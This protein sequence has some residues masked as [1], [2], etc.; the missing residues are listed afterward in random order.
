MIEAGHV[1]FPLAIPD[2]RFRLELLGAVTDPVADVLVKGN[3]DTFAVQRWVDVS[4]P[5]GGVTWA[6]I[7]APLVSVGD[8]RIF[9]WDP[10]Y[11]PARAHI[12]SS[13]LNNGWSTNFQEFQGGDFVFNFALRAHGA[14]AG[15]DARFGWETSTPLLGID[16]RQG[17]GTLPPSASL[18]GVAPENVVLVN[19]K[20]AEDGDGWIVRLYE[21][22][23]R[24]VVAR[25][26]WGMQTP[27]SAAV[28]RLTEDPLPEGSAPLTVAD[29]TIE[30]TIGPFEIQTIRVKF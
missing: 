3:R 25:V 12:Y 18:A 24:R 19:L 4:G 29:K 26:T 6:T 28:T 1:A 5:K 27:R 15:P 30:S 20:R 8:I 13:V 11:V 23:G 14:E 2:F 21:T 16:V 9:S 7:E 22:A 17:K 10:N